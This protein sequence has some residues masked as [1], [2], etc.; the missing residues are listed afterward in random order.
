LAR[1]IWAL[2]AVAES[3]STK[4]LEIDMLNYGAD[5][6]AI[7]Y[8]GE[9]PLLL[10]A[11]SVHLRLVKLFRDAG[12]DYLFPELLKRLRFIDHD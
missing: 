10:A 5:V 7:S 2:A 6:N 1:N 9:T 4:K 12:A 3:Q 11:K 8:F